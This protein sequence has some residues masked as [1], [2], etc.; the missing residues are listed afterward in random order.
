MQT[1]KE[2]LDALQALRALAFLGILLCHGYNDRFDVAGKWGVS[3]FFV[4][5]GFLMMYSY[6]ERELKCSL[7][8]NLRFA[9][10]KLRRLYPLHLIMTLVIAPVALQE[11]LRSFS[12]RGLFKEGFGLFMNLTL[13]QAW[14]PKTYYYFSWNGVAWYLSACTF[15]YFMFPF[16]HRWFQRNG[17]KGCAILCMAGTFTLMLM[18]GCVGDLLPIPARLSDDFTRWFT[19]V[20]PL[21]RLGDFTMGCCLGHLFLNRTDESAAEEQKREPGQRKE[22]IKGEQEDRSGRKERRNQMSRGFI[23][24]LEVIALLQAPIA[25]LLYFNR[26]PILGS[27]PIRYTLLFLPGSLLL[28]WLFAAKEGQITR[29]LANPVMIG[30]GD[31]TPYTFL[32]HQAVVIYIARLYSSLTQGPSNPWVNLGAGLALS[33]AAAMGYRKATYRRQRKG[34]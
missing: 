29:F 32:I 20:S 8:D 31:L 7:R 24:A 10:Q 11:L 21:Y 16:L 28:V 3:V 1:G 30:L 23:T 9:F 26:A 13:T 25:C 4:L 19:Y 18:A 27:E 14:M 15:L 5:S 12:M 33:V 6:E 2:R 22:Q 17:R 34:E